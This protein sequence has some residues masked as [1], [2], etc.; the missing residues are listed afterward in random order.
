MEESHGPHWF[1]VQQLKKSLLIGVFLV[2]DLVLDPLQ[3]LYFP[4]CEEC[5]DVF[6]LLSRLIDFEDLD[7][8]LLGLP[9]L[10]ELELGY[11][12]IF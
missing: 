7:V 8:L 11:I 6:E 1:L 3:L 12:H 2:D 9:L 5:L 4:Y 10:G